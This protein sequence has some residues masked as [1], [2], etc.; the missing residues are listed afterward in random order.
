MSLGNAALDTVR[1][2]RDTRRARSI[3]SA[4]AAGSRGEPHDLR[5][6]FVDDIDGD[7]LRS[8]SIKVRLEA[9]AHRA[10][11]GQHLRNGGVV[12]IA[13]Q[14]AGA[15]EPELASSVKPNNDA[16]ESTILYRH[17]GVIPEGLKDVVILT[18]PEHVEALAELEKLYEREKIWD[19]LADVSEKQA[20]LFSDATKKVAMLQ[21]L[22]L[23][24]AIAQHG[25]EALALAA[26][27]AFDAILMD[28]ATRPDDA[29]TRSLAR[30]IS[31][32]MAACGL[33]VLVGT[34]GRHPVHAKNKDLPLPDF[35]RPLTVVEHALAHEERAAGTGRKIKRLPIV[36]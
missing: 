4:Q 6:L 18:E 8:Q 2:H 34:R 22:G 36:S 11:L 21:K 33:T 30:P 14:P 16:L 23:T 28:L 31:V 20:Q 9:G 15:A 17:Y 29:W 1:R 3:A 24:V 19:K 35:D 27:Q 5:P 25:E 13:L 32:S 12:A 26:A 7:V 10:L